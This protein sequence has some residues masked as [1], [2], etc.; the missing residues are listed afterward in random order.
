MKNVNQKK[1]INF[2]LSVQDIE[3]LDKLAKKYRVSRVKVITKMINDKYEVIFNKDMIKTKEF[4]E[5][6]IRD[7]I[8]FSESKDLK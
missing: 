6:L 1:L 2:R 3:K 5:M 4:L 7:F 8:K